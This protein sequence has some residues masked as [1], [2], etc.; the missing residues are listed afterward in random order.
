MKK[1]ILLLVDG[2]ADLPINGTTPL[3]EAK[4]PNLDWLA[5]NGTVAS[6]TVLPK[7]LWE[8][9]GYASVSHR[10][11]VALLGYNPERFPS[12]RGPLEA[13]GAGVPYKGGWLAVRCNFATVDDR[14]RV[15]DRRAGR[16]TYGLNEIARSINRSVSLRTSF[17]FKRTYGHRAV[18]IL[19]KELSD[20][21]TSNDPLETG[22][23]V[24]PIKALAKE[25]AES[26]RILNEFINK[27]SQVMQYHPKNYERMKR[28]MEQANYLLLRE[29]GNKLYELLPHFTQRYKLKRAVVIAE[30]GVMKATC[31]LAGFDAITMPERFGLKSGLNF[32]FEQIANALPGYDF[33]YAHLKWPDEAAHDGNFKLKQRMIERIDEHLESLKNF[34][35]CLIVTCDHIT[36]TQTR[37]HEPG[38]V[39][40]LIY[41]KKRG[42]TKRFDEF[43][44]KLGPKLTPRQ[45]WKLVF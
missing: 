6:L 19:R 5:A 43:S 1:V 29:P 41:G 23:K 44:A 4:K 37:K 32:V 9:R 21:I 38:P 17:I 25:A 30:P 7:K 35:G 27:A 2:L 3:R 28:G 10:A 22:K 33:V 34:K 40:V 24:K 8:K 45:L 26:A 42:K 14:L 12:K 11:N 36:S 16:K 20:E 39:P 18:L 13:V 31:M 15:V